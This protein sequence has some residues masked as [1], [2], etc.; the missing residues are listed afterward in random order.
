MSL[1]N[2]EL[3]REACYIGGKWITTPKTVTITNPATGEVL[4]QVPDCGRKEAA[5]AIEAANAAW[6]GWRSMPSVERANILNRWADLILKNEDELARILTLEQG[7]PLAESKGEI[8]VG[9]SY[10]RWNAEEGRRAYGET[11]PTGM[12]GRRTI[13]IR[14]PIGVAVAITPWNFPNS[15]ITRK[16]SPALAAGCPIVIKPSPET[17]FSAIALAVLAEKA[18]MPKGVFSVITGNAQEIGAEFTQNPTVRALS[19]TGST[20]VGKMLMRECADTL[21]KVSLELGGNAPFIVFDDAD[22]GRAAKGA[23][24][25]KFRNAGQTCICANRIFVQEGIHDAFVEEFTRLA[26][27]MR[28]GN[29]LDSGV[30]LGPL[31][32]QDALEHMKILMADA[33]AKGAK[34]LCG[35]KPHSLGGTFFEP[36]VLTNVT[37]DMRVFTDE[38]FGPI[39]PVMPFKTEEEA[40]ALANDTNYGLAGYV[41]SRDIGRVWRVGEALEYGM[42][43]INDTTLGISEAPFGGMKE[44]GNGREGG[45]YG[46]D[47]FSEVKYLLLGGIDK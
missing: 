44:S 16:V 47:E 26:Q 25:C 2:K 40:I 39:A 19:F 12:K 28:V 27:A 3:L 21:K 20:A 17:P 36:T 10:I 22:I 7:K 8:A 42:V 23:L 29:G 5:Q 33:T 13:T 9:A 43:G 37:T 24:I 30:T 18:G 31:I 4:G 6:A 15:M 41:Y 32:R 38:I 11:I 46:I 34:V 14:Q 45:R 35:G 1:L